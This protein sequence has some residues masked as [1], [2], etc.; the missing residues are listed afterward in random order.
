MEQK[1]QL[2]D[3]T[4]GHDIWFADAD[5]APVG[6]QFIGVDQQVGDKKSRTA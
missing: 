6:Q 5:N 3:F 2:T 1:G 4:D